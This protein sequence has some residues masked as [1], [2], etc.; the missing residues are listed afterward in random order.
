MPFGFDI[1]NPRFSDIEQLITTRAKRTAT[2]EF[3]PDTAI[4]NF[5]A[6]K[7]SSLISGIANTQGG[8]IFFGINTFRGRVKD[9]TPVTLSGIDFQLLNFSLTACI[10]PE[11]EALEWLIYNSDES[12]REAIIGLYIPASRTAPHMASDYRYYHRINYKTEL[13]SEFDI[14]RMYNLA[15]K[16]DIELLGMINTNGIPMLQN[17]KFTSM[18]FY[19]KILIRNAGNAVE[20]FLKAEIFIPSDLHDPNFS[21]LQNHFTRLEGPYSVF[22]IPNRTPLFQNEILTLVEAKLHLNFENINTFMHEQLL[23]HIYSSNGSKEYRYPLSQTF[24]YEN[25]SL[26]L[27]N[28][29][30]PILHEKTD[31]DLITKTIN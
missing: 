21:P 11:I 22:A 19:P 13:M 25:Q 5:S 23:L 31:N 24:T 10:F 18:A 3:L 29:A 20:R 4:L 2:I 12:N 14:R 8:I 9:F 27:E 17:G 15:S 7:L 26:R 16:S 30:K 1:K 6:E 28:F